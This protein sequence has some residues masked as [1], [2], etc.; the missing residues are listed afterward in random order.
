M[1]EALNRLV[2]NR[3]FKKV[4]KEGYLSQ[5]AIRLVHLRADPAFQ[6]PERQAAILGQID[7]I[8]HLS[9]YFRT[10]GLNAAIAEKAIASDEETREELIAEGKV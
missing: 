3:D 2:E 5:E 8:S 10:V 4:I 6:T 9:A 7:A 1:S